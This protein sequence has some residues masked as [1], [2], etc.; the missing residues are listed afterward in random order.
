MVFLAPAGNPMLPRECEGRQAADPA[1]VASG[2]FLATPSRTQLCV[3]CTTQSRGL[4]RWLLARPGI[5]D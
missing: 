4:E 1:S 5:G 3:L 2:Y